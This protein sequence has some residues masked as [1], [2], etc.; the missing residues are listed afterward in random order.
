MRFLSPPLL[1][2]AITFQLACAPASA[3]ST[4]ACAADSAPPQPAASAATPSASGI[5]A[6]PLDLPRAGE[7]LSPPPD[8]P[9]GAPALPTS[10]TSQDFPLT[11]AV[12]ISADGR[13]WF[14]GKEVSNADDLLPLARAEHDRDPNVRAIIRA[15]A[16]VTFQRVILA[17]D[18]LKQAGIAKLAFGVTPTKR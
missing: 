18:M 13:F 3:P 9:P 6:V 7:F 1:L 16:A 2:G 14:N 12:D 10:K 5:A 15:D 11:I 17:M 4:A 8:P